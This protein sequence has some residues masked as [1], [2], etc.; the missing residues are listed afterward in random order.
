MLIQL[1]VTVF[2]L[3]AASRIVL[4]YKHEHVGKGPLVF[5]LIIWMGVLTVVYWPNLI[6]RLASPF[7]VGRGIDVLVYFG[8][9]LLFYLVYRI[10]IHLENLERQLTKVVRH[11]AMKDLKKK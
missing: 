6:D 5:W 9:V 2:V 11:L 3:F 7:G 8:L 4:Q 1:L 10:Y